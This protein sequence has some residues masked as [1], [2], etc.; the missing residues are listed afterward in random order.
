MLPMLCC[1]FALCVLVLGASM[2]ALPSAQI[3]ASFTNLQVFPKDVPR[4]DLVNAMKGITSALGVRCTYCHVGPDDLNGMD[5]A[6]DEKRTKKVARTMMR[7]VRSINAD[8]IATIPEGDA[9]KQSVTCMTCHRKSA[10]PTIAAPAGGGDPLLGALAHRLV[11]SREVV[12]AV[13]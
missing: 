2:T 4:S 9:P 11:R 1:R 6:T 10:I 3:P 12:R 13:H 5:F 8:Y 7:M